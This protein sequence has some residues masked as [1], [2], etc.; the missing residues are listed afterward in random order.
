MA[1]KTA[2]A[3]MRIVIAGAGGFAALL[4][5]ELS[6]SSHG[7]LVLSRRVRVARSPVWEQNADFQVAAPRVRSPL[8]LPSRSG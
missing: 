1:K 5:Q 2:A 3:S 7:I 6:S 8:R 4:A